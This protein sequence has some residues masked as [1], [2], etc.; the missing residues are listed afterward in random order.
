MSEENSAVVRGMQ[1]AA[2]TRDPDAFIAHLHPAV[3]WEE[4]GDV[5]PG[6]RGIYRGPAE[7]RRW[8]VE[9][10]LEAWDESRVEIEELT[11]RDERVFVEMFLTARGRASGVETEIRVWNV[12]RFV[13]G[14]IARRQVFW[15]KDEA[16][17]AAGLRE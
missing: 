3:E 14:K 8:F 11:E 15:S 16:L 10:F 17:E 5:L 9:A 13:D 6:L 12:F 7:V 4:T 2:N 1:D